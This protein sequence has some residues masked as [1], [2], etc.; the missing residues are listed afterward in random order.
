MAKKQDPKVEEG[1]LD[2]HMAL[3][4]IYSPLDVTTGIQAYRRG[5]MILY[6]IRGEPRQVQELIGELD[7]NGVG[8]V[9]AL[10]SHRAV[11][12]EVDGKDNDGLPP[13]PRGDEDARP[14]EA[15]HTEQG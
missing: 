6:T 15:E 1:H 2:P 13:P 3:A 11:D 9:V 10:V 4:P 7:R 12:A 8:E 14:G 5:D